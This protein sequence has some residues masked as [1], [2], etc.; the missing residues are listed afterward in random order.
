MISNGIWLPFGRRLEK[1]SS[2]KGLFHS[3]TNGNITEELNQLINL[4]TTICPNAGEVTYISRECRSID[5]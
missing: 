5:Y 1:I 2:P 4:Q 3:K